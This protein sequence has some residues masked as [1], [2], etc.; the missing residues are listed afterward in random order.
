MCEK[1][2]RAISTPDM[3]NKNQNGRRVKAEDEPMFTLTSMD[4]HGIIE[5]E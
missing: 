3:I 4:R 5:T 1:T 2:V